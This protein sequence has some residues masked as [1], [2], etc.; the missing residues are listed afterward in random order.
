MCIDLSQKT[1]LLDRPFRPMTVHF[2][3]KRPFIIVFDRILLPRISNNPWFHY[4]SGVKEKKNQNSFP[5]LKKLNNITILSIGNICWKINGK[6]G[7]LKRKICWKNWALDNQ[8]FWNQDVKTKFWKKNWRRFKLKTE[9][10]KKNWRIKS[11]TMTR[12]H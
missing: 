7:R 2:D 10:W 8:N 11:N 1:V 9:N 3:Q 6:F 4:F 5:K 12:R